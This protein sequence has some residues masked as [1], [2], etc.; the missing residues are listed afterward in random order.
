MALK[1]SEH[2]TQYD[3]S[4]KRE[5]RAD[6]RNHDDVAIALAM[7]RSAHGEQRHH[8][9][10]V[11]QAVE[12]ARADDGDAMQQRRI[13]ALLRGKAHVGVT[14]RIERDRQAAR[15]RTGER[16]EHI[17]RGGERNQRAAANRQVPSRARQRR[18]EASR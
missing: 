5:H 4:D 3:D 11:R 12:R 15:G 16:G 1:R 7:R 2:R 14:E 9:A 13:D 17:G 6:D 8:R 10:V 18:P